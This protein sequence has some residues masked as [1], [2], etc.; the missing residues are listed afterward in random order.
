M[1]AVAGIEWVSAGRRLIS[2]LLIGGGVFLVLILG[3]F[4]LAMTV[5]R[6]NGKK[7][8]REGAYGDVLAAAR[9]DLL[10]LRTVTARIHRKE[11]T[12]ST[13]EIRTLAEK[14]LAIMKE[15]PDTV[16]TARRF[17]NYYLP[18]TRKIL[19]K[20]AYLEENGQADGAMTESTAECL[21]QIRAAMEQQKE[22][23]FA[24]DVLDLTAEMDVLKTMCQR[25]GILTEADFASPEEETE[26]TAAEASA[27]GHESAEE[28]T[29]GYTDELEDESG[30]ARPG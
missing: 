3:I 15:R 10:Q 17:W 22:K 25:D 16:P 1:A 20:F 29:D 24:G 6:G 14:I 11:I 9:A 18:T 8:S 12:R 2:V 21:S 19:E 5:S 23:L 4:V 30:S 13:G 26:E 27:S 28:F 7:E